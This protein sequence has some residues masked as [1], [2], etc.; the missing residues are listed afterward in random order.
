MKC[1]D[2]LIMSGRHEKPGVLSDPSLGKFPFF[3]ETDSLRKNLRVWLNFKLLQKYCLGHLL[4]IS[5]VLGH[6]PTVNSLFLRVQFKNLGNLNLL[7]PLALNSSVL[8]PF[9]FRHFPKSLCTSTSQLSLVCGGT[10]KGG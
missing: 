6:I 5:L 3:S 9:G 1:R 10:H 4:L 8:L 2:L 7:L